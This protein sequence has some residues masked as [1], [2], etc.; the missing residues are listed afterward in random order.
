MINPFRTPTSLL[1]ERMDANYYLPTY[2]KNAERLKN[3]KVTSFGLLYTKTGIGHTASVEPHYETGGGG[4]PFVSGK[5]IKANELVLEHAK[6]IK[7]TSHVGAMKKSRLKTGLLLVVRKGDVGNACVVPEGVEELNCSSEVMFFDIPKRT[8]ACFLATFFNTTPGMLLVMREQRGSLIP[9][10]SL[11]D[12]PGFQVLWPDEKVRA[13]IGDKVWQA[14][15]LRARARTLEAEICAS[16]SHLSD[17]LPPSRKAWRIS[18]NMLDS[19]RINSKQYDPVVLSMCEEA[20][21][22]V[23]LHPVGSLLGDRGVA[24]G[25]TPLGANY[26]DRGVFFV[27]V[28]NVKPLRLDLSDAVYLSASQDREISRSRCAADDIV[29]TITGEPGTASLIEPDDLPVN[30]NQH[31]VRFNIKPGWDAA[32]VAAALNSRFVELQVRRYAIG[33]TRDA[34]DYVCVRNLLIPEFDAN[35]MTKISDQVRASNRAVRFAYRLT[36][37]AKLLV[38]GLIDGQVS[39]AD[40]QAAH[41]DRHKDQEILRRLT[42]KGLAVADEPPLFA[43]LD[44]LEQALVDAGGPTP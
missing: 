29:F 15:R 37:A 36:I 20:A 18:A 8:D 5:A 2:L 16:F 7:D 33:G 42:A 10:L 31:S 34:L 12:I 11:L 4:V 14:E 21:E 13:Y 32:Y 17:G 30:I 35:T 25:A 38:E 41:A 39:E 6:R 3:V 40:L 19:Y 22:K 44:Q 9:G 24:G 23:S 27:R 43:D 1:T 26:P 28:Q